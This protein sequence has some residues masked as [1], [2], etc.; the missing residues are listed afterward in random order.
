VE[1]EQYEFTSIWPHPIWQSKHSQHFCTKKKVSK[2]RKSDHTLKLLTNGGITLCNMHADLKNLGSDWFSEQS[3]ANIASML[4][5]EK[6]GYIITYARGSFKMSNALTGK[7]TIFPLTKTGIYSFKVL[8]N[9]S[10]HIQT[11]T[12]SETFF[13]PRQP[14]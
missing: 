12:E 13:T 6:I 4:E 9:G 10:L 5:A 14:K 2:I 8:I 1:K 11:V 3:I 7:V